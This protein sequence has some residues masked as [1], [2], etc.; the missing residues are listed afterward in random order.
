MMEDKI[1]VKCNEVI[2]PLRVKALPQTL[3]C[4]NCST[5][6]AK[7]GM[8]VTFG[9]KDHTWNDMMIIEPGEYEEIN[10]K[11]IY[12]EDPDKIDLVDE[13]NEDNESEEYDDLS[14]WDVTLMDGLEDL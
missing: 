5:V 3:T 4:V 11:P 12:L 2:H 13:N 9:E 14:D 6:G 7:K 10:P 8:P 1:C